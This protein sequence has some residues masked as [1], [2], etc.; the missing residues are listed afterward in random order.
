MTP[1][2][3][4]W[5]VDGTL[6]RAGPAGR[7]ALEEAAG[8]VAQLQ[9]IPHVVMS[10]KSDQ[11]IIHDI[12]RAA[13]LS[14][15]QIDG[16]LPRAMFHAEQTLARSMDWIRR[17][18]TTLPGVVDL[19]STLT[20]VEGVR[21]TLVTGNLKANARLK[22]Q[23]F[24]LDRF[25]DFEVG[26]YGTDHADRNEL[27]P[28]ALER[29]STVRGETYKTADVWVIGD[30]EHDLA[31]ARAAAVRCLLVG[32][33]ADGFSRMSNLEADLV[34]EDLSDTKAVMEALLAES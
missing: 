26:A 9:K 1:R 20:E 7:H 10:G 2:L 17:D 28:L 31:C 5:D 23:A 32:N 24:H 12:L 13:G 19:L 30:T 29:V 15:E 6:L 8:S 16:L 11:R 33:G 18:G 21:Q 3:I 25:I 34:L 22:L 27:V 4:L 14:P